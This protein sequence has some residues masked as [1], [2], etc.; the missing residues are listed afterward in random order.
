[1]IGV[2]AIEIRTERMTPVDVELS[3]TSAGDGPLVL[4]IHGFPET[5]YSWRHQIRALAE[6]G[7]RVVAPDMRGY[8]ASEC[9]PDVTDYDIFRLTGDIAGLIRL[10]GGGPAVLV[11]HDWGAL[12]SWAF[13]QFRPDLLAGIVGLSVPY[14]PPLDASLI[15]ILRARVGPEEFHYILHFQEPDLAEAELDADPIGAM[16]HLLWTASGDM[17]PHWPTPPVDPQRT[18]ST[19]PYLVG[20]VPAGLPQW[21]NQGDVDAYA[22]AFMR[23]GFRGAINW[24][25]NMHRNWELMAPWR[26]GS[27][28][29]PAAYIG[30]RRDPVLTA[31]G[32]LPDHPMLALQKAYC[33]GIETTLIDGGGHWIQ[34]ER[35]EEVTMVLQAFCADVHPTS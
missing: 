10:N 21:I 27:I 5:A 34:Q 13:A 11:G 30:G 16:R 19:G 3:V 32:T 14:S 28:T 9:P 18:S 2:M 23:S 35:P 29:I 4:L 26:H 33:P 1:M 8:G 22:A 6:A 17:P 24:Y 20:D 31:T 15:D 7:Y 12:A 25:R